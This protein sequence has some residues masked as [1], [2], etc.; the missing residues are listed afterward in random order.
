MKIAKALLV[1]STVLIFLI[2]AGCSSMKSTDVLNFVLPASGYVKT[3]L[4]YGSNPRQSLDVYKPKIEENTETKAA[5]NKTPIV[6][7]YGGAWRKGSKEDYE[8]V[9]HALVGLGHTVIVPDYRLYP[10]AEFPE[11]V[12]DVAEAMSFV[13]QNATSLLGKPL[14]Q[15]IL[16]GHSS[17]AHTA[18]LLATDPQYLNSRNVKTEIAGLIAISGPYDLPLDDP[19]VKPV[20]KNVSEKEANPVFNIRPDMPPVLL[21]HGEK[22]ERVLPFHSKRFAKAL[23]TSGASV[24]LKIYPSVNHT[25]II[26]SLAAPL[27]FL[28]DSYSDIDAFLTRID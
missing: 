14:K 6:F 27:R 16:M 28:N 4:H 11:F 8:F 5:N 26:G 23:T 25:R 3:T 21:L 10:E 24:T 22:D 20:F 7:V 13:E 17:G 1:L 15:V 18:A 19:E 2:I 9:A 12:N